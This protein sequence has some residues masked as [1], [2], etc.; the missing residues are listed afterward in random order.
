MFYK[1]KV[2]VCSEIHTKHTNVK[3][4]YD[5][6]YLRNKNSFSSRLCIPISVEVA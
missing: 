2:A 5:R 4:K 6:K 3:E 1:A